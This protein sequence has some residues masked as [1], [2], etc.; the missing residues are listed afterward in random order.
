ML[1]REIVRH[2][3]EIIYEDSKAFCDYL[4]KNIKASMDLEQIKDTLLI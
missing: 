4:Y 2:R 3:T 1:I